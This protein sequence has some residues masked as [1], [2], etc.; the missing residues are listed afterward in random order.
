MK[1]L[2]IAV[3]VV[4]M[5]AACGP[6]GVG[7]PDVP[8]REQ[9]AREAAKAAQSVDFSGGNA[10]REN[11]VKRSNLVAQPDLLGYIVLLNFGQ[12]VA[13]YTIKGKVTSSGKRLENPYLSGDCGGEFGT[14]DMG[15]VAPSYD[16]TYG[17]SDRYVY[18]WT[19]T[20]QYVQWSGDYLYSD[21]PLALNG[22]SAATVIE[23][24]PS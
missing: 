2:V 6:E 15:R 16:G 18:F 3:S 9:Q 12:P 11:I 19:S 4:A 23:R 14:C 20:G 1:K 21:Q 13:Y 5:L 7:S 8:V 24:T 10:E 17:D 22:R